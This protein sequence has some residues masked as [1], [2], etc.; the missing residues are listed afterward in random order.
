MI[1]D[2]PL[3][4]YS[5]A[6]ENLLWNNTPQNKRKQEGVAA[7]GDSPQWTLMLSSWAAHTND[8]TF[9]VSLSCIQTRR[10]HSCQTLCSFFHIWMV[11]WLDGWMVW[12]K[13]LVVTHQP[14]PE[15][16][17]VSQMERV[18]QMERSSLMICHPVSSRFFQAFASFNILWMT[19]ALASD[20]WT[21]T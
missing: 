6:S 17:M 14:L 1:A 20:G 10:N 19:P 2:A 7:G 12:W 13:F 5:N 3:A 8:V 4:G 9:L 11:N 16:L 18:W 21:L 15:L